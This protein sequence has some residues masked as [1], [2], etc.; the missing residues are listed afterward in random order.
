M[1]DGLRE[2]DALTHALAVGANLLVGRVHQV[3]GRQ[4]ARRGV[5]SFPLTQAVE[6]HERGDP[7]EPGHAFVERVLFRA[8]TDPEI[9]LR[10]APDR[11]AEHAH[12]ALARTE[13]AGDELHERGLPRA[14]RPEEAGNAGRHVHADVVEA[15]DLP[16]PLGYVIGRD[17]GVSR[18]GHVTTSTP[19]TRR[20]S[21][22]I[23]RAMRPRMT[24]N[25]TGQGVA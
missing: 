10:V 14:V 6:A 19:R 1:D 16:V 13:L 24:V 8:E 22:E 3:D 11:L 2:L 12:V 7:F 17:D 4:G 25:D 21:T 15:D 20:S 9:E 18:H 23:E 5:A